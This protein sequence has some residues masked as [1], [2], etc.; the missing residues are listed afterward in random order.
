MKKKFLGTSLLCWT[1]LQKNGADANK[2]A[3]GLTKNLELIGSLSLQNKLSLLVIEKRWGGTSETE[4]FDMNE[5]R[6]N[7]KS[8]SNQKGQE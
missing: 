3:L 2:K 4:T 8:L 7:M 5:Y 6:A 1:V